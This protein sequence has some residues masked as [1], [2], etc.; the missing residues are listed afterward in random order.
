MG[1]LILL[2]PVWLINSAE[3]NTAISPIIDTY[4]FETKKEPEYLKQS[5]QQA[6]NASESELKWFLKQVSIKYV[7]DYEKMEYTI[8]GESS[9]NPR[10]VGPGGVSIGIA[11]FTLPTWLGNCTKTDE[12]TDPFKSLDCMGEL[13]EKGEMYRWDVYCLHYYDEKCVKLRGLSPIN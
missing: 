11:Q 4:L 12:R 1:T 2:P 8:Q 7:Q 9:F 5:S 6:I 10:A 3:N 13:W